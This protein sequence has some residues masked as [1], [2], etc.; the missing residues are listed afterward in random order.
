MFR[1]RSV[2]LLIAAICVSVPSVSFA[3]DEAYIATED[4]QILIRASH[5]GIGP[6]FMTAKITEGDAALRRIMQK[7]DA[8]RFLIPVFEKASPEGKCYALIGLRLLAPDYFERSGKR[9]SPWNSAKIKTV[10]GCIVGDS[11]VGEVVQAIREGRYD[12]EVLGNNRSPPAR[13]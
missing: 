13:K 1:M 6:V 11:T 7:D 12:D 8:I 9:M 10:A 3:S 5:F 2:F 4:A